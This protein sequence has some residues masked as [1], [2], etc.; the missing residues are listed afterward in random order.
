LTTNAIQQSWGENCEVPRAHYHQLDS[1]RGLAAVAVAIHH[2]HI[3]WTLGPHSKCAAI[4]I[5]ILPFRLLVAGHASVMM[6]FVLSGFVLSLPQVGGKKVEYF[7]YL[8]KR[9]CRIYLPYLVSLGIAVVACWKWH[10]RQSYGPWVD[11]SWPESPQWHSVLQHVLFIGDYRGI[12]NSSFWTLVQEM[13]I[14]LFFP[15]VCALAVRVGRK[16]SL[17]LA[18]AFL[19]LGGL[20]SRSGLIPGSF[21]ATISYTGI[22]VIGVFLARRLRQ[23]RVLLGRLNAKWYWTLFLV[24]VVLYA[25]APSVFY[26]KHWSDP[27]WDGFTAVGAAGVIL[28]SLVDRNIEAVLH[29]PFI[30]FL[31]KISFSI[32]LLHM[33]ILL[34][35]CYYFYRR[36]LPVFWIAPYLITTVWLA[37]VMYYVVELPSIRLGR[38]LATRISRPKLAVSPLSGRPESIY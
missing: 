33:P 18:F 27:A 20:I 9:V 19:L 11:S 34:T 15:F 8:V 23:M 3:I 26:A 38:T 4:L 1:L 16:G 29:H 13:R 17:A 31:G 2:W 7:P 37:S 14:S 28:F 30:M 25:Y 10:G 22:F 6:F 24:F 12:Y 5:Q 36:R 21:S 35:F 32:Y